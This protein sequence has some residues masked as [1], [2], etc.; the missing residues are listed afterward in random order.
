M[1]TDQAESP[2]VIPPKAD[3][4]LA[5]LGCNLRAGFLFLALHPA[6]ARSLRASVPQLVFLFLLDMAV[7]G[8]LDFLRVDGAGEFNPA[9]VLPLFFG[10]PWLLLAAWI[11]ARAAGDESRTV[12]GAVALAAL[13][14][15][16][17]VVWGGLSLLPEH[18][19]RSFGEAA[20][21]VWWA[22]FGLGL[23]ASV[24]TL[25]RTVGLGRGRRFAALLAT[26]FLIGLPPL[27]IEQK[28]SLWVAHRD[29]S[30]DAAARERRMRSTNESVL[31]AQPHLLEEALDRVKPGRAGVPELFLL[32]VGG[33]GG[34]DVFLREVQSVEALFR[35]RFDTAGHSMIL[36]NNPATISE[37]PIASV[38]ALERSLRV[39]GQRMNRDE[40]VLVLFMTSHGSPEHRFDLSLWPYRFDDLTPE[41]LQ[42]MLK[43][44]GIRYRVVV[45]SA[46]YSGGF[47]PPLSGNDTLVI[48]A[49]RR[50]RNSHGCSHEADWTFFGRAFFDEALR[51]THSF[52]M[53]FEQ[54]KRTV[55]AR[56][57]VEGLEASEPQMA[58]GNG[59]RVALSAVER[60][61]ETG[62]RPRHP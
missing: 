50:D 29:L 12:A 1:E 24:L 21:V 22:P 9:G 55:A 49:A 48:S 60:R 18:T 61:L 57:A 52:E 37:R 6:A 14:L 3:G 31:Y 53:A 2:P 45:V 41:R 28:E 15:A 44:A 30:V 20:M 39:I 36:V 38:T 4:L 25:V 40:D 51:N 11:T 32:A 59:I 46:C 10:I 16:V 8:A 47:V 27:L 23:I 26:I 54:A 43:A 42:Q 56:E 33:H 62:G 7:S 5:E 58:V 19:W 17:T 13:W 34:Q 35:E